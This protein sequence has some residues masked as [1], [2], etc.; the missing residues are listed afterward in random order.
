MWNFRNLVVFL[1]FFGLASVAHSQVLISL[2]LGDKLNSD[3]IEFGLDSGFNWSQIGNLDSNS[4]LRA[5][6]IGSIIF[7][8]LNCCIV[9]FSQ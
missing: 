7:N 6:K 5:F 8:D 1:L 3:K 9:T 2:L 4:S